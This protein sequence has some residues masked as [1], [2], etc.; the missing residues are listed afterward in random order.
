MKKMLNDR[1]TIHGPDD[2]VSV[3]IRAAR[4]ESYV[5]HIVGLDPYGGWIRDFIPGE[6]VGAEGEDRIIEYLSPWC[7][8][9][10]YEWR[11][12]GDSGELHRGCWQIVDGRPIDIS[13][14]RARD[15]VW[16][17]HKT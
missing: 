5:A 17:Q 14:A 11:C 6:D 10:V 15:L 4:G 12:R 9:E 8:E 13:Y 2:R 7:E 1:C 3:R 16:Q